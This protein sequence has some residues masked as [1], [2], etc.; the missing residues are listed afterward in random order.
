MLFPAGRGAM[1]EGFGLDST[2]MGPFCISAELAPQGPVAWTGR[3][4]DSSNTTGLQIA[5]VM[6]LPVSKTVFHFLIALFCTAGLTFAQTSSGTINGTVLD[7]SGGSVPA[8]KIRLLG[9]E[10]GDVVRELT[11]NPDGTF[12]APLLRPS[13]YTVEASAPGFKKLVR[14]GIAL[15]VDD[16]LNLRLQ[17]ELGS[18]SESV[19][20][21]ASAELL[22]ERTNTIGETMEE[23]TMQ[24]LPLNGRNYLQ[25]GNLTAGA[26]PNS[27]SRDRTFSAYGNRGLQNAFLL[28]GAR[29]QNYLRGLDNRARDAM[30]PSLEAISEFKVQ[31]SNYS[32]EYGASAGAVVT[33][34]TKSGTNEF[35]GSAFEF[36]RN[37]AFDARDYFL[38]ASAKQA[39]YIQHQFGGSLGG[40][41]KRNRIWW[42]S[43]YQRT[44]ITNG[45]TQT[46]TV[47]LAQERNGIFS[48]PIY[49]PLTTRVEN[50]VTVRDLFLNNTIPAS[51]FDPIG[52]ALAD[53]YPNPNQPGTARNYV[54]SPSLTTRSHNATVRGDMRISDK[55]SLFVRYSLDE[56][57]FSA[58]PL[59]PQGAQ[60]GVVRDVPARS[61][62]LGYTRIV[63]ASMVNDLRIAYNYVGLTQDATLQKAEI[64][65][66]SIDPSVGSGI[67]S[68][69]VTN[70]A[71]IGARPN[72]F[73]NVPVAKASYVY[74]FSDNFSWVRGKQTIKTG[75]DVQYI[76]V[77]TFATLNGRGSFGFTG[78]FTQN[79][80]RRPG[81]GNA[82]ADLLLGFPNTI[83]MGSPSDAQ[84]RARNSYWYLQDDWTLTPTVS[85]NLGVRYELTSPY[86]DARNRLANLVLDAG[87]P[88]YG[89]YVL[90]GDSRLPRSLQHT[91]KNNWA[92]RVGVAWKAPHALVV[93][94]GFGLFYA[95]DEAFG[96]SQRMTNN[97]PWVGVGGFAL[98]SDQTN[99]SS[100][101]PLSGTLPARPSGPAASNYNFDPKSTVQLRSWPTRYTLPYVEQWNLSLQKELHRNLI[102]EINY[103]GNHGVKLYGAYEGNQPVPGPGS[104]NVRR[105]L[106]AITAASILRVEPWVTSAYQGISTRLERRYSSGAS[107]LAVYTF[108]RALD[109][110]T[111]IDL[112]D[113]CTNSGGSGSVADTRN[114]RLN[115]GLSDLHTAHRFVL[116]GLYELP[117]GPGKPML[118]NGPGG[119]L[120]G[121]WA[122]SGITT[123]STGLPITLNLN[124]DNAN[125]GNVNW[126]D[127]LRSG[128][129]DNSTPDRWFD[130][131]AFAFPAQYVQGNAGRNILTGPGTVSTDL[132]V[133]RNF[134]LP[135]RE[136][137]RLE[138]RAEA[139]NLFNKPQLG[140]P[141]ATLGNSNFGVISD[142]ARPNRQLQFGLKILF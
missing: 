110:Q 84:E 6:F 134:R 68:F 32:A 101:I 53:R 121:G 52:K 75:V 45:D 43:A 119:W 66:G 99:I 123:V 65:K 3:G 108:G 41:I 132:S 130:T 96:V 125:T 34:V 5:C 89:Q 4:P 72:N 82:L 94:G 87:D 37:N 44:L 10:T 93:R 128:F 61:W 2:E 29:N 100:T 118:T 33:V 102:W 67:P 19:Q 57:A 28:D 62:G 136:G 31:T 140:Q 58:Q 56:A 124:F 83:T 127:R 141:G 129:L 42:H 107:F 24:E 137:S 113:G 112:C 13:A 90:A 15:N 39:L 18:A 80:Q 79:P 111:N 77:P 60:T 54:N 16:T 74:N 63:S 116:S 7:A 86:Y 22:E 120:L 36:L 103:V 9:T 17:L 47:P 122:L 117:F 92:P 73:D 64:V 20:V 85:V 104:A 78:V 48:T 46:G 98:V 69:N 114:R 81:S 115:Y 11:T 71:G 50:G 51:R 21:S 138:F 76:D 95:Q 105:P 40:P 91:D 59:L 23:K 49:D 25:L 30:R 139:F 8:A 1:A 70:Y 131:S 106:Q 109:M 135:I 27:R 26:V 14:S 126:P 55:D 38:P 12:A 97:P 88:L 142:T 133:Q 35:H